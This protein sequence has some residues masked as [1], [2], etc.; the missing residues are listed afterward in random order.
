MDITT[1]SAIVCYGIAFIVS[2]WL[3]CERHGQ[4]NVMATGLSEAAV[5]CEPPVT[6]AVELLDEQPVAL[7][8]ESETIAVNDKERKSADVEV[9][10][11][12]TV[13]DWVSEFMAETGKQLKAYC[14]QHQ[15]KVSGNKPQL[16]ARL[17]QVMMSKQQLSTTG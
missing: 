5:D 9:P 11:T 1:Q 3:I 10:P 17:A 6:D 16:A 4:K 15:V 8:A 13:D 12:K 14:K 2:L 7:S